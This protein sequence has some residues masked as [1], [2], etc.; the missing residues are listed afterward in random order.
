M[1]IFIGFE[2]RKWFESFVR[3][4]GVKFFLTNFFNFFFKGFSYWI[5]RYRVKVFWF[6]LGNMNLLNS[7]L[8]FFNFICLFKIFSKVEIFLIKIKTLNINWI[9]YLLILLYHYIIL[10]Q[11]L[12]YIFIIKFI[13]S[14]LNIIQINI[15][16]ISDIFSFSFIRDSN[17]TLFRGFFLLNFTFNISI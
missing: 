12:I 14:F 7:G 13:F 11:V 16:N 5:K 8:I 10:I 4:L 9:S 6:E 1:V 17:R 15:H 2:I 3:R